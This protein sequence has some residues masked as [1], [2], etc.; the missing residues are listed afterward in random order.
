MSP[1]TCTTHTRRPLAHTHT[2]HSQTQIICLS[3]T[4]HLHPQTAR[5]AHTHHSHT[6]HSHKQITHFAHTICT[7]THRSLAHTDHLQTRTTTCRHVPLADTCHLQTCTHPQITRTHTDTH[8]LYGWKIS[9][10]RCYTQ[11]TL[12]NMENDFFSLFWVFLQEPRL[13]W[14]A[15]HHCL[16]LWWRS[17]T[18]IS[19]PVFRRSVYWP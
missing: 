2:H 11:H 6:D 5:F 12:S 17:S 1:S 16:M 15:C 7:P 10:K 19:T 9:C 8:I 3:Y 18:T 14:C 13:Y 4:D